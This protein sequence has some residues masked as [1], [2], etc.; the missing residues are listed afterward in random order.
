MKAAPEASWTKPKILEDMGEE[1]DALKRLRM[2]KQ[3]G[4]FN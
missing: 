4:M 1:D 3:T 2:L